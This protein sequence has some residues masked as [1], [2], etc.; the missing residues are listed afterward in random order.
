MPHP[1]GESF[2][3]GSLLAWLR[4]HAVETI[5]WRATRGEAGQVDRPMTAEAIGRLREG[6][7]RAAAEL[8]RVRRTASSPLTHALFGLAWIQA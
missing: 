7:L 8:D 5:V 4:T 1:D 2:G 3:C 6:E